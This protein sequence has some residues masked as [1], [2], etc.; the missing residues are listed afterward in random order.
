MRIPTFVRITLMSMK[1]KKEKR[2][3]EEEIHKEGHYSSDPS[4]DFYDSINLINSE[5]LLIRHF[6]PVKLIYNLI[7]ITFSSLYI[8]FYECFRC[9]FE[10]SSKECE[11]FKKNVRV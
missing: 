8:N 7:Y 6:H 11:T 2:I 3:N 1:F 5:I 10:F 9:S 4:I